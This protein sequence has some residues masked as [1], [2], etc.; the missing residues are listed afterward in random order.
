MHGNMNVKQSSSQA[1]Y[2]FNRRT[3]KTLSPV[4]DA[5]GRNLKMMLHAVKK[6]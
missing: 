2:R 5:C 4:H 3:N 6:F 1:I